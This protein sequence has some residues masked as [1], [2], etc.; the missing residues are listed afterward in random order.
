MPSPKS[1]SCGGNRA[2]ASRS[3]SKKRPAR[4]RPFRVANERV[5]VLCDDRTAEAVV[6]ADE[7]HVDVLADSGGNRE[8][9]RRRAG[10]DVVGSHE[11]MVVLDAD[12]PV[13]SEAEFEAGADRATPARFLGRV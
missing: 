5:S 3:G 12:R 6:Q 1:N 4:S 13:R 11:Q 2:E 9:A 8:R 7:A 10:S